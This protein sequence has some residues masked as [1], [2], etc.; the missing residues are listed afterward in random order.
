MRMLLLAG[1][2]TLLFAMPAMSA[3]ERAV[4]PEPDYAI[5]DRIIGGMFLTS[6]TKLVLIDGITATGFEPM[7][8]PDTPLTVA[9]VQE[10]EFFDG[11]LP[12][13]LIQAFVAANQ[14][15]AS[16][17][18]RFRFGV[19]YRLLS[20]EG[21]EPIAFRTQARPEVGV[22]RFSRIAYALN[23]ALVY[24]GDHRDDGEGAGFLIWFVRRT[25]VWEQVDVDVIWRVGEE[26]K[27]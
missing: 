3:E 5:Y 25:G 15:P 6:Q 7:T 26:E 1:A 18:R 8:P 27:E 12:A 13:A 22:L 2:V 21:I 9:W 16:L 23:Q 10:Q 19:S 17:E 24:V 11:R 14:R 20:P 4:V